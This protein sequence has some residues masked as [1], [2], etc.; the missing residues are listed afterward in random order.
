MA[1]PTQDAPPQ[2]AASAWGAVVSLALG[3]FSLVMSEFLPASLLT[4]MAHSLSISEGQ[5]G[6]A[7]TTTALVALVSGL[8]V[9]S[10]TRGLDRRQVLQGFS[11]ILIVANLTVY[12]SPNLGWLLFGRILLGIALGGFWALSTATAMRLVR[13]HDVPRAL[14]LIFTGVPIA[15][16]SAAALGSFLGDLLGWRNVFLIAT[17]VAVIT[18]LVQIL[19]LPSMPPQRPTPLRTLVDVM[20]RPGIGVG[21]LAAMLVFCGHFAFFTY[22]RPFLEQISSAGIHSISSTLLAFGLA[23]LTGTLLAGRWLE[24]HLRLT[25]LSMPL[26]MGAIA[27]LL[28][29]LGGLSLWTDALMITLWGLAFGAVPVAWS[30]W[31]TRVV[32]DEAESAGGLLGASIQLAI[33]T[34][35]AVGGVL[36]DTSG[37]LG[38]FAF[39]GAL[40]VA[41]ALL[42]ATRVRTQPQAQSEAQQEVIHQ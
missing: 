3:V 24:H 26:A 15:T 42:I 21:I 37:V 16:I 33:A 5:A 27:W 34:G 7:V 9:T 38:T 14:S 36:F 19:T 18:L 8:L 17:A 41:V 35:A 23:N 29:T 10:M 11:V 20:V 40:L 6:Q 30:T 39:S 31:L 13:E 2:Q 12:F 25:L 32:A 28:V 4:P 22:L 1:S